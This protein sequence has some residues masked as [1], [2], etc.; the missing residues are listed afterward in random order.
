[1]FVQL[2]SKSARGGAFARQPGTILVGRDDLVTTTCDDSGRLIIARNTPV[3]GSIEVY[4]FHGG[5]FR[6]LWTSSPIQHVDCLAPAGQRAIAVASSGRDVFV[7]SMTHRSYMLQQ[8]GSTDAII[9]KLAVVRSR[10]TAPGHMIY[11]AGGREVGGHLLG[12]QLYIAS[13]ESPLRP[14]LQHNVRER[15]N[16]VDLSC[17]D[18]DADGNPEVLVTAWTRSQVHAEPDNRPYLYGFDGEQLWPKWMGSRLADPFLWAGLVDL[19]G[20]GV[21][22]LVSAERCESG[23]FKLALYQWRGFGFRHVKSITA[24]GRPV[25]ALPSAASDIYPAK[26]LVSFAAKDGKQFIETFGRGG[27]ALSMEWKS[28]RFRRVVPL[29]II[30]SSGRDLVVYAGDGQLYVRATG[31]ERDKADGGVSTRGVG[32]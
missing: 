17:G 3:T 30:R 2:C 9:R 20:R 23:Q 11:I 4:A 14:V 6:L 12:A 26:V 10:A 27:T 32:R 21:R 8:V 24:D 15:H 28:K 13:L 7:L 29:G 19:D 31:A 5:G 25:I 1:M 18:V 16:A 22:S